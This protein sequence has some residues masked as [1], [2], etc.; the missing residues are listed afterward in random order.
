MKT[1][2]QNYSSNLSTEPMYINKCLLE[3]GLESHLWADPNMSTFDVF[4]SIKPDIFISHYKFLT[5]DIIKYFNQN[6]NI[7]MILNVTGVNEVEME[8]IEQ[9]F[10]QNNIRTPFV[11]TNLYDFSHN[12]KPKK[13]KLVNIMPAADI[14]L[15]ITPTPSFKIDLAILSTDT[16]EMIDMAIENKE[17]YH[18]LSLGAENENFDLPVDIRSM[19]G[20]YDKY[21]EIILIDDVNIVS[22]Q[23]L[24]EASLRAKKVS[25]RVNKNQQSILDKILATL[26]H[27]EDNQKNLSE[28]IRN[29]IKRK[30]TCFNRTARLT[31]F[32]KN[33]E[34]TKKLQSIIEK[35]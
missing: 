35:L 25:V 22:S 28:I 14:F 21:E 10:D 30:H 24:F 18:L 27:A 29:Q 12:I 20:L 26:F 32:L 33:E 9:T 13:I 19:V 17:I 2:V 7:Q 6:Q 34:A 11:F 8:S 5:N 16:N 1:L 31:R 15:P 3:C 23:I 4:D